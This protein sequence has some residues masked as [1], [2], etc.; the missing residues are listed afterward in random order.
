MLGFYFQG[1]YE[2]IVLAGEDFLDEILFD[3]IN[4]GGIDGINK[5][6]RLG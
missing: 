5:V 3:G 2:L 6:F 1:R 4:G